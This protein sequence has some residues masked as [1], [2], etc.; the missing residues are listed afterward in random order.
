MSNLF[1]SVVEG[2]LLFKNISLRREMVPIF[3]F[4]VFCY[5]FFKYLASI[6]FVTYYLLFLHFPNNRLEVVM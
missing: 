4:S 2:A 6:P 5:S 1:A 3:P